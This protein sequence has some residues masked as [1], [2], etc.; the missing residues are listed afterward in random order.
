MS[1][2][3]KRDAMFTFQKEHIEQAYVSAIRDGGEDVAVLVLD[4]SDPFA[5][6]FA[7]NL[8]GHEAVKQRSQAAADDVSPC[9]ILATSRRFILESC[10]AF[11]DNARQL[12]GTP[13]DPRTILCVL[14]GDGG[15]AYRAI[16]APEDD[17]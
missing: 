6:S 3:P 11:S 4:L 13:I 5:K 8:A 16:M 10:V 1:K 2:S 12:L 7:E 14:V 15:I 17:A 9:L